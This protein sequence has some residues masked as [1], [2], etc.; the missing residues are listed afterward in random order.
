[1]PKK[2]LGGGN[3]VDQPRIHL[4]V[5]IGADVSQDLVKILHYFWDVTPS[6]IV[7]RI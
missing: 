7:Y 1:M 3:D 5:F 4:A 2:A 6:N